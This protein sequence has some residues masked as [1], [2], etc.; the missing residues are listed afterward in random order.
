MYHENYFILLFYQSICTYTK[1][2][3]TPRY[4]AF[5][6]K[7]K[8]R[9]CWFL[10]SFNS[11]KKCRTLDMVFFMKKI[12]GAS[13]KLNGLQTMYLIFWL[14]YKLAIMYFIFYWIP[15]HGVLS[16]EKLKAVYENIKRDN[17][18][19]LKNVISLAIWHLSKEKQLVCVAIW[20]KCFRYL[21]NH[22]RLLSKI[23]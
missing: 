13:K 20:A 4:S 17:F 11:H 15:N 7:P 1:K 6:S 8:S 12:K 21:L 9:K 16:V 2:R 19:E 5:K 23:H 18:Q 14:L 22:F 3:S 10:F